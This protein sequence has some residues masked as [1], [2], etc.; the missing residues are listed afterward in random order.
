MTTPFRDALLRLAEGISDDLY[1]AVAYYEVF[2]P[3]GLD[4]GLV[5]RVNDRQAHAGFNVISEALQLG[6]IV[7]LCRVWDKTMGAARIPELGNRLRRHPE[8]VVDQAALTPWMKAVEKVEGSEELGALRGFRNV[9]LAHRTNPDAPDPRIQAGIRRVVNGDERQVLEWTI[10]IIHGFNAMLGSN[11]HI[12]F[13]RRRDA[14]E[15]RANA[16]WNVV[17]PTT[18]TGC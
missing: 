18:P 6:V 11:L 9:G 14:W 3:S 2:A 7:S 17:A 1:Q 8:V 4:P 10:S 15:L 5:D 13:N 16:F 12:D